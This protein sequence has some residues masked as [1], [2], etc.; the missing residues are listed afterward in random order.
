MRNKITRP[1]WTARWFGFVKK[2]AQKSVAAI[3]SMNTIVAIILVLSNIDLSCL[4]GPIK[5]IVL[6]RDN[7]FPIVYNTAK[8]MILTKS[9][10]EAFQIKSAKLVVGKNRNR[11]KLDS[12]DK[13][14]V[15]NNIFVIIP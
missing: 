5:N 13:Y 15:C 4:N 2:N 3:D 1:T 14:W 7:T 9:K 10:K 11:N 8:A 6:P 12:T